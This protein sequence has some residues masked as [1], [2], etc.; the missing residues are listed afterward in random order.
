MAGMDV[1][2]GPKAVGIEEMDCCSEVSAELRI[3]SAFVVAGS[4]ETLGFAG[5]AGA[6][7][8][9]GVAVV[10]GMTTGTWVVDSTT[11]ALFSMLSFKS[12]T[13]QWALPVVLASTLFALDA[14]PETTELAL[15][16]A[17]EIITG[18]GVTVSTVAVVD[19]PSQKGRVMVVM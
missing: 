4:A 5:I 14:M 13:R 19:W 6:E 15:D 7:E 11:P 2:T 3:E 18:T 16:N 1:P 9:C 10:T 12:D 17:L 8:V